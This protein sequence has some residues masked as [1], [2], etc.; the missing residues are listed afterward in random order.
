MLVQFSVENFLSFDEEKI[1]S[2]VAASGD[3]H[4]THLVP[5][6]P[7]K[8]ESLLR[9]AALYGANGAGKSNLVQAMRFAKNLIVEGTRGTQPIAVRPFKLGTESGAPEQV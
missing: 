8:G 4:P 3:Q 9:A 6:V 5:D 7:R 1:F 2:M